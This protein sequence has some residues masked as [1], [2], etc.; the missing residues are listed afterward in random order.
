MAD[1]FSYEEHKK[2]MRELLHP[3]AATAIPL[4]ERLKGEA[5]KRRLPRLPRTGV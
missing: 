5:R 2:K 4:I 3:P 1:K